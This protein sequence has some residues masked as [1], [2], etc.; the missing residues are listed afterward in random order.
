MLNQTH[1][2]ETLSQ[3]RTQP[4]FWCKPNQS[5]WVTFTQPSLNSTTTLSSSSAQLFSFLCH[6][7]A[8]GADDYTYTDFINT[9][10]HWG[11]VSVIRERDQGRD[12]RWKRRCVINVTSL[13]LNKCV[14]ISVWSNSSLRIHSRNLQEGWLV[15]ETWWFSWICFQ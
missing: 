11:W 2:P 13:Q 7:S 9:S 4:W 12:E 10:K 6:T 8:S 3:S 14:Q 5:A 15:V 1:I